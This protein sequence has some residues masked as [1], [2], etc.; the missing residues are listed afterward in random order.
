MSLRAGSQVRGPGGSGDE[1]ELDSNLGQTRL[2]NTQRERSG[3]NPF[4]DHEYPLQDLPGR[5]VNDPGHTGTETSAQERRSY[6]TDSEARNTASG[7]NSDPTTSATIARRRLCPSIPMSARTK[8]RLSTAGT[9]FGVAALTTGVTVAIWAAVKTRQLIESQDRT[10]SYLLSDRKTL[11]DGLK[12]CQNDLRR[13]SQ[14]LAYA[15]GNYSQLESYLGSQNIA[16]PTDLSRPAQLTVKG[17]QASSQP[18]EATQPSDSESSQTST[19][20]QAI[21]PSSIVVTTSATALPSLASPS[22]RIAR[23]FIV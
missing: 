13:V 18:A 10:I 5:G 20:G 12:N 17:P 15:S 3:D 22:S 23:S 4:G 16:I 1:T 11:V 21:D 14:E 7:R 6:P 9:C 8:Q 2:R 19:A